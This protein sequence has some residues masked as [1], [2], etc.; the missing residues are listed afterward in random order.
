MDATVFDQYRPKIVII[1]ME[2]YRIAN[3]LLRCFA[4]QCGASLLYL[5]GWKYYSLETS[6]A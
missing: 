6:S 2:L 4:G 3:F 1:F 5:K